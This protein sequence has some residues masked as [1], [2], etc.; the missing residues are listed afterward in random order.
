MT[1]SKSV[2]I[3]ATPVSHLLP[4]AKHF[5]PV[6]N[7]IRENHAEVIHAI[8]SKLLNDDDIRSMICDM[9]D[10]KEKT[11][12]LSS[13]LFFNEYK[14]ARLVLSTYL[15]DFAK[16]DLCD[17]IQSMDIETIKHLAQIYNGD[18]DLMVIAINC[19]HKNKS[20]T[21]KYEK[22]MKVIQFF[23]ENYKA[24]NEQF[25]MA[26]WN[27]N[28]DLVNRWLLNP[29]YHNEEAHSE[30]LLK[31]LNARYLNVARVIY[32]AG[33]AN[34]MYKDILTAVAQCGNKELMALLMED[35][36]VNR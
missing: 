3:K 5:K 18:K 24:S 35:S 27:G 7:A 25:V 1:R 11:R 26:A 4:K 19:F 12:L 8:Q 13:L 17:V 36:R 23:E 16:C 30:A 6:A 14:Y 22:S 34:P 32:D 2:A 29:N 28:I 20:N 15:Q 21:E 9:D 33:L 31:A 10:D